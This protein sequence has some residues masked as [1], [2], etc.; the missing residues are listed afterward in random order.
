MGCFSLWQAAS[1]AICL[2]AFIMRALYLNI[3]TAA[4]GLGEMLEVARDGAFLLG[5]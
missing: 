4:V 1:E 3:P 2:P 5:T